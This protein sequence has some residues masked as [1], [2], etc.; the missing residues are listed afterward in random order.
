MIHRLFAVCNNFQR[1]APAS[2]A[3]GRLVC[4]TSTLN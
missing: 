2:T 1:M 4:V 3:F